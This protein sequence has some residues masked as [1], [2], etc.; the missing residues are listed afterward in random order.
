MIWARRCWPARTAC[1]HE[2]GHPP[3]TH[4]CRHPSPLVT[5]ARGDCARAAQAY[6]NALHLLCTMAPNAAAGVQQPP[7]TAPGVPLGAAVRLNLARALVLGECYDE[8]VDA[9]G[10]LEVAAG[11]ATS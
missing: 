5:E 2:P 4:T 9:Y 1:T 8:A 11:G 7:T 3:P 10:E 6:R